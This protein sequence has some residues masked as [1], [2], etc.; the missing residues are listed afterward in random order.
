M[1]RKREPRER[2]GQRRLGRGGACTVATN[3]R[4]AQSQS[5]GNAGDPVGEA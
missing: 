5:V 2:D 4:D 3:P 1:A